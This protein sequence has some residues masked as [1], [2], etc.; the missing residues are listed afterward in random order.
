MDHSLSTDVH[1]FDTHL[2]GVGQRLMMSLLP[3][4]DRSQI[5]YLHLL[6]KEKEKKKRKQREKK[7]KSKSNHGRG[8]DQ[9]KKIKENSFTVEQS[10]DVDK[11]WRE[12]T[13]RLVAVDILFLFMACS[14]AASAACVLTIIFK[15]TGS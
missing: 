13:N 8:S 14:A 2:L 5:Q 3:P 15:W 10:S 6:K 12:R 4:F 9:K 11:L 1:L 7:K